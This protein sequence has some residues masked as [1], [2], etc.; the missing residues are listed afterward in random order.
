MKQCTT[1][2]PQL[3]KSDQNLGQ[4]EDHLVVAT[5]ERDTMIDRL[6]SILEMR[7]IALM[8]SRNQKTPLDDEAKREL[9]V[10]VEHIESL[11]KDVEYHS[12][13]HASHV[14]ISMN[15]LI[16]TKCAHADYHQD[17]HNTDQESSHSLFI[18]FMMV[19]AALVHDVCHT[20]KSN[21][22]LQDKK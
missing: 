11:Y 20:G 3:G 5:A 1:S 4:D 6:V 21:K 13:E 7:L 22:I 12:F 19:Y 2:R 17:C 8:R 10:Y 9:R 14:T 15:K 16:S 18:S